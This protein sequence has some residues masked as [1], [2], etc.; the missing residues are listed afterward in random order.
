MIA[1]AVNCVPN[2]VHM[3]YFQDMASGSSNSLQVTVM[4]T[5]KCPARVFCL[6][7]DGARTELRSEILPSGARLVALCSFFKNN[8]Y[9]IG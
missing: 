3:Q 6:I 9:K 2:L 7:G 8:M 4:L 1:C 5:G